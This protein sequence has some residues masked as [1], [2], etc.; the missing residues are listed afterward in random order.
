[1]GSYHVDCSVATAN[2][3]NF[4]SGW[5]TPAPNANSQLDG[6]IRMVLTDATVVTVYETRI[7]SDGIL[8]ARGIRRLRELLRRL[9]VDADEER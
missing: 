8:W 3:R 5:I 7:A 1:M 4:P 6:R 2:V 9:A